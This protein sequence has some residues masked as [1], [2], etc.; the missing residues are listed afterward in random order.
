MLKCRKVRKLEINMQTQ[1]NTYGQMVRVQN[2]GLVT[3][4]KALRDDVGLNVND[5]IRIK[6]SKGRIILEPVRILPYQVRSYN[7]SDLSNFF[8]L[9]D[10]EAKELKKKKLLSK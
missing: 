10:K 5:L 4:P 3:I 1:L 2:K 6:R 8:E 9:D 7:N